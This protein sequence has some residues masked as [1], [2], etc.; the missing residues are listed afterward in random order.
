MASNMGKM[1]TCLY[2]QELWFYIEKIRKPLQN[3]I[4][5][6]YS[7][8]HKMA[9]KQGDNLIYS[10]VRK[11]KGFEIN[12][13]KEVKAIQW[14]LSNTEERSERRQT[15]VNQFLINFYL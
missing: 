15:S 3:S 12:L 10:S 1:W 5:F 6:L 7:S 2:F 13:N 9:Q 11:N 8:N 14:N 4:K